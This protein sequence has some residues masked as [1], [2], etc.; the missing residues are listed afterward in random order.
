MHRLVR[1]PSRVTNRI[2][3][4]RLGAAIEAGAPA[5]SAGDKRC[6]GFSVDLGWGLAKG[7]KLVEIK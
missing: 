3:F 6:V 1:R 7:R 4:S 2:Q 5:A